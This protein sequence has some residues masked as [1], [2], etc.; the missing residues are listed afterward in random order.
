MALPCKE[1]KPP[2]QFGVTCTCDGCGKQFR[3]AVENV[4]PADPHIPPTTIHIGACESGG[5]YEASV[6]CPLC[7]H[8]HTLY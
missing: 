6:E 7:K 3:L 2:S 1:P 4:L 5:M 8:V